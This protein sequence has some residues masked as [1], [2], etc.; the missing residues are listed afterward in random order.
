VLQG[1]VV[2]V[3]GGGSGI[4]RGIARG[5]VDAG[6]AVAV[7]DGPAGD[8]A[9]MEHSFARA[10]AARGPLDGVVHALLD[11]VALAEQPLAET[12]GAGWDAR[13]E[14][15][16]RAALCCAQAAYTHLSERG[17]RLVLLTPTVG[18]TG[19]SG[20]VPYATAVEGMR[21]MA[22]SAARQWGDAGI[23]VNCVA[24]PIEVISDRPAT[25]P[26]VGGRALRRLPDARNDVAPVV[27]WLL[28]EAAHFVTGTTIVVDGGVVMAP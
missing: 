17:G 12:D 22:K 24:P 28:A 10:A 27:A 19:G 2:V 23:T 21:A 6:A 14:A 18:L 5:L 7:V 8:R 3:T 11:S 13:C 20:L 15:V 1:R 4:G 16:L 9:A 25:E 26:P